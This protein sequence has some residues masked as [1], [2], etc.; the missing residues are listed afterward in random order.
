MKRLPLLIGLVLVLVS[1]HASARTWYI[2][3]DGTGDAPT[4]QAGINSA[5][6]G[7][8]LLLEGGTY[9]GDGNH[10]ID[11][12]GKA[13]VVRSESGVA[14]DCILECE[15][16]HRGFIFQ[17]G[18]GHLAVLEGVTIRN[19]WAGNGG[20]MRCR[21]TASPTIRQ[22]VFTECG[23]VLGGAIAF[24]FSSSEVSG[25][26]FSSNSAGT[27]GAIIMGGSSLDMASCIF[28][29]NHAD[30]IGGAISC[31]GGLP[32][33]TECRFLSNTA[34]AYGGVAYFKDAEAAV[35]WCEF[36]DNWA[37]R[38]GAVYCSW[39]TYNSYV[40]CTFAGNWA[41]IGGAMWC[42]HGTSTEADVCTFHANTARTASGIYF[43]DSDSPSVLA[44]CIIAYGKLGAAVYCEIPGGSPAMT[45]CDVYGNRGGDWVGCIAGQ[46]GINGNFSDCPSFCDAGMGDFHLCD[47]SPCLPGNHPYGYACGLIGAWDMGCSCG[48]SRTE[49]STWSAL[50]AMYR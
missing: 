14:A 30:S 29:G 21:N 23:A 32:V 16:S 6:A 35:S 49:G 42:E 45:C 48:P 31:Q 50:K 37:I 22:C 17:N 47:E 40:H 33:F 34:D 4:I 19:A 26:V 11:Y 18:E 10:D 25:C 13:L 7:D 3:P 24:E 20:G 5:A 9:L 8:T 44:R 39:G 15:G 46:Y 28:E 41:S 1:T 12:L 43:F 36:L 2:K 27:G 38:G